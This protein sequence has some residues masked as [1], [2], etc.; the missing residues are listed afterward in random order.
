MGEEKSE[1]RTRNRTLL[2]VLGAL[3]LVIAVSAV[4]VP[5][6]SSTPTKAPGHNQPAEVVSVHPVAP[7]FTLTDLTGREVKLSDLK[8]QVVIVDFWATWC[9]PCRFETPWLVELRDR[10]H[11]QG[12]EVIGIS[13]DDGDVDAV[14]E[15]AKEFKISY[16][17]VMGT[18]RVT[19]DYGPISAV[20]TMFIVDRQGLVRVRHEGM[21]SFADIEE[22]IKKLL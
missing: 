14:K 5:R 9:G 18:Q 11:K 21:M 2:F 20:P 22:A 17:L 10:Y 16:P 6:P 12:V 3:A 19:E 8:G 13:L 15:F 1:N 7:D 4:F